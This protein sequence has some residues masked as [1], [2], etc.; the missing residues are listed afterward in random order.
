MFS[1]ENGGGDPPDARLLRSRTR[2]GWPARP[3]YIIVLEMGHRGSES[4]RREGGGWWWW[5]WERKRTRNVPGE[6]R[7]RYSDG[8]VVDQETKKG[9]EEKGKNC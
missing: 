1:G 3:C 6:G 7:N 9:E 8:F 5:W 4:P 2:E